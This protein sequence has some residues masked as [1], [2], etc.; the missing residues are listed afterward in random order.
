MASE[1]ISIGVS[2]A[3][4]LWLCEE[5]ARLKYRPAAAYLAQGGGPAATGAVAMARLGGR[6]EVWSR[7]GDDDAGRFILDQFAREG[8]DT[9]QV[10]VCAG[11]RSVVC[12]ALVDAPTGDRS[13]VTFMGSGLDMALD[14]L[15][16][17]R[18]DTAC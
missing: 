13:F 14:E 17:S 3:D 15:N 11:G 7:V 18:I 4:H 12:C 2:V 8:V 1:L 6:V 16:L 9:S 5:P 10:K